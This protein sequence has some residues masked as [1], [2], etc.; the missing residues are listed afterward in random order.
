MDPKTPLPTPAGPAAPASKETK[1][2]CGHTIN[3]G[4]HFGEKCALYHPVD[5]EDAKKAYAAMGD[6]KSLNI[7]GFFPNCTRPGCTFLHVAVHPRAAANPSAPRLPPTARTPAR[8]AMMGAGAPRKDAAG[9]REP[10][11]EPRKDAAPRGKTLAR[12]KDEPE[13]IRVLHRLRGKVNALDKAQTA[14]QTLAAALGSAEAAEKAELAK[15]MQAEILATL[16]QLGEGIDSYLLELGQK[17]PTEAD[18]PDAE[19]DAD[20]AEEEL[21]P[22]ESL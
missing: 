21:N 3:G 13:A 9:R 17:V 10:R 15:K 16:L 22:D 7:C 19:P 11:R 12:A 5:V 20:S 1:K 14:Y 2:L 8:P 18:E 4:C 6:K